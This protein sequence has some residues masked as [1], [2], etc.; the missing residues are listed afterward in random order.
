MTPEQSAI[1]MEGRAWL[2]GENVMIDS[3]MLPVET[4]IRLNSTPE[5]LSSY[6]MTGIDPLFP[7]R[8]RPGDVIVA[9]KHF[10]LGCFHAQALVG[11]KAL[12]IGVVA[13][14]VTR[15][16]LRLAVSVGLPLLPFCPEIRQ[17][18]TQGARISVNFRTGRVQCGCGGWDFLP[19]PEML[20]EIVRLGGDRAY[21]QRTLASEGDH[22]RGRG[23][24]AG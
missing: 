24:G 7:E 10:G 19:L 16:F 21:I 17:L 1:V 20:Y 5:Q 23:G 18:V 22:Q 13:E 15:V 14:S 6:V 3:Q 4:A 9:G 8:A 11:M 12:G 2:F